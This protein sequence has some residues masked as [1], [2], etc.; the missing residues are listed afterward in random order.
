MYKKDTQRRFRKRIRV[1]KKIFGTPVRPRLAVFRSNYHI[2]AQLINDETGNTIL[3]ASSLSNEIA[4]DV[5]KAGSKVERSKLVGQLIAK[6]AK[7]NKIN[8]VVFDR[9]GYGYH[10]RIKAV[11]EGAREGGL[12]F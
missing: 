9:S 2:Y 7:E 1:R 6:K 3:S 10:G 11:A 8:A 5:K 4:E 12:K